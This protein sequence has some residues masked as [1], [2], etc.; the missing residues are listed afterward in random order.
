[1][2]SGF[3]SLVLVLAAL[4]PPA[5]AARFSSHVTNQ[6]FPLR[7]GTTLTY[8][9]ESDGRPQ[10]DVFRVTRRTKIV[11]GVRCR[12][13]DDRVYERGR[14]RER[15]HD[16]Y[17]QDSRGTVWYFGEDTAELD[18][19]GRVVSR[20]G[21]WHAGVDGAKAGI[22]M[23]AHPRVGEVHRQE[24]LRGHAEDH[25]KVLS[26]TAQTL[27]TKEWTPLEP[28][29]VD[30]KYYVRGVGE[31]SERTTKGGDERFWLVR[32]TRD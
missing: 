21:T 26:V 2:R 17:A 11:D 15:T 4:A 13:V 19:R 16:Y 14:L 5:E 29:V 31:V 8:D 24:F 27:R 12:V 22:F 1:M 7:P 6:W 9:G 30:A 23:P 18:S 28:G 3:A 20:E 10:R 25:F 32:I